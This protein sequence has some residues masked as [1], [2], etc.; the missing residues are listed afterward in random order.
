MNEIELFK[1]PGL[2][3]PFKNDHPHKNAEHDLYMNHNVASTRDNKSS[4]Y[5]LQTQSKAAIIDNYNEEDIFEKEF[6]TINGN[7]KYNLHKIDEEE[8][9]KIALEKS[10]KESK[11]NKNGTVKS[12]NY[13]YD[14]YDDIMDNSYKQENNLGSSGKKIPFNSNV[15][16]SPKKKNA[17]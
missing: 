1:E 17:H 13:Q 16:T 15:D 2:K 3:S 8:Q 5:S 14:D 4:N 7:H 12:K 10:L 6:K 11:E 9:F